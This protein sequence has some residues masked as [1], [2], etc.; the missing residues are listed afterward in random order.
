M[1]ADFDSLWQGID[2]AWARAR[3]ARAYNRTACARAILTWQEVQRTHRRTLTACMA[4]SMPTAN[5]WTREITAT[6]LASRGLL[7]RHPPGGRH[8]RSARPMTGQT[9]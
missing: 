8:R 4:S 5:A 1:I 9:R 7:A 3:Q 2:Q 6:I